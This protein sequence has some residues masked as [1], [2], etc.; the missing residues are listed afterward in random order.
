MTRSRLLPTGTCW[1]G[2]GLDTG[3]GSFWVRGHDKIA[4]GALI[5]ARYENSVAQ[6]LKDHGYGPDA[7]VR[8]AAVEAGYWGTCPSCDYTGTPASIRSHQSKQ[9]QIG[10]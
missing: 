4:E 5:A 2:C 7:S 10:L 3:I 8:A 6:M 9:H 1:C